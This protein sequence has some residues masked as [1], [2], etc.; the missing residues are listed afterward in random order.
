M[1]YKRCQYYAVMCK[2]IDTK[3]IF[4]ES[5]FTLECLAM[6][7]Y[8]YVYNICALCLVHH[9]AN[10]V[11]WLQLCHAEC[12]LLIVCAVYYVMDI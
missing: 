4:P 5:W 12:M 2:W 11:T 6:F 9:S 7:K 1:E 10:V 8:M 3:S